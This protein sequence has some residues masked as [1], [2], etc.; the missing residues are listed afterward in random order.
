MNASTAIIGLIILIIFVLIVRNIVKN[1]ASG[2]GSCSC[3]CSDC[4]GGSACKSK[5]NAAI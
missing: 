1:F 5:Q 2:K 4:P 3:G